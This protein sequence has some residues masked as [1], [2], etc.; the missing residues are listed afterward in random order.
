MIAYFLKFNFKII[1]KLYLN[2][3]IFKKNVKENCRFRTN[4]V[5]C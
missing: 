1:F 2:Y 5:V 3:S 4:T